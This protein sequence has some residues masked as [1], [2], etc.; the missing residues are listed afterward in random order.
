M[1]FSQIFAQ[2]STNL[3][4]PLVLGAVVLAVILAL[5]IPI[6]IGLFLVRVVF[7]LFFL[8]LAAG[9]IWHFVGMR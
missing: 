6:K 7:I 3:G 1:N 2:T 9:V 5:F 8:G 4:S